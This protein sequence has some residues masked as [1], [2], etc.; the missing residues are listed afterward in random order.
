M[1][2]TSQFSADLGWVRLDKAYVTGVSGCVRA[3]PYPPQI[4]AGFEGHRQPKRIGPFEGCGW[5]A[6][7][8]A[9]TD[10]AVSPDVWGRY[11]RGSAVDALKASPAYP[12]S[13]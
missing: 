6:F 4:W 3:S 13:Q 2:R 11:E 7:S 12:L 10:R 9:V 1:R 5:V 8:S